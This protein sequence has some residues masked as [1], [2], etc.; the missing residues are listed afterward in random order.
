[1]TGINMYDKILSF[2]KHPMKN[3]F[4][5]KVSASEISGSH[6]GEYEDGCLLGSW[7]VVHRPDDGDS[8]HL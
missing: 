4:E 8:K 6:G 3:Q 1:M 2:V 7:V 5:S